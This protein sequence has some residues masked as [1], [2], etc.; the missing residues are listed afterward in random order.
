MLENT[1][2]DSLLTISVGAEIVG[3]NVGFYRPIEGR[4]AAPE[5]QRFWWNS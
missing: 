1:L 3:G 2:E 4:T 5:R